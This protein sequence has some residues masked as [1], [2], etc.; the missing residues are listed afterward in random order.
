MPMQ[1]G[2][3]SALCTTSC[4]EVLS[5][6]IFGNG[7][8]IDCVRWL[9]S[10]LYRLMAVILTVALLIEYFLRSVFRSILV[11]RVTKLQLRIAIH[12][13]AGIEVV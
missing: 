13:P 5:S 4:G 9:I 10:F 1:K 11:L 6:S 2:C 7:V 8:G 3:L 12:Q